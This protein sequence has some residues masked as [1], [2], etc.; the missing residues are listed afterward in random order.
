[1]ERETHV[2]D[3]EQPIVKDA[4]DARQGATRQGVI[5]VLIGGMALAT[6]AFLAMFLVH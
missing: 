4:T 2:V 3:R 1:M 6:V 5:Y